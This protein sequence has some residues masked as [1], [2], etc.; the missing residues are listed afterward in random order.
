MIALEDSVIRRL[1]AVKSD[2]WLNRGRGGKEFFKEAGT[3]KWSSESRE[4]FSLVRTGLK[5][6]N[7]G[8]PLSEEHKMA[9]RVPKKTP[10][11]QSGEMNHMYGGK[12]ITDGSV[13]IFLKSNEQLPTG[14]RYG[15]TMRNK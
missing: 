7:K 2:R 6:K 15:R 9:L 3:T 13:N 1:G 10:K 4:N 14:F 5:Q 11:Q 8:K 12:W